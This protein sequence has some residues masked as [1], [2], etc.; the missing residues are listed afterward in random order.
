[1]GL[2]VADDADGLM[3]VRAAAPF[4]AG[5]LVEGEHDKRAGADEDQ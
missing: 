4:C 3:I 2:G 1:M 5:A